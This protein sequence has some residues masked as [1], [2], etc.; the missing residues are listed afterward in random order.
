[1]IIEKLIS[2]LEE[3]PS[4]AVA[5]ARQNKIQVYSD[6]EKIAHIDFKAEE[7]I[8]EPTIEELDT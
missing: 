2:F 7:L 4:D 3:L 6:R 8:H 5:K 1:M